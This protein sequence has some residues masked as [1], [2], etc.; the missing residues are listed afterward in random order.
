MQTVTRSTFGMSALQRRNASL[1]QACS[2]SGVW[3]WLALA[4]IE[5]ESAVA[6]IKLSWNF[7]DRT[8]NMN[9]PKRCFCELWVNEGGLARRADRL[10]LSW[11]APCLLQ[12]L[13]R[14]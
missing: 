13:S 4:S 7:L 3:A 11:K 6:S 12:R 1:V 10:S 2:S 9:P 8:A 14:C 5:N